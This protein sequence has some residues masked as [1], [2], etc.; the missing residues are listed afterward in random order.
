MFSLSVLIWKHLWGNCF[1]RAALSQK[2]GPFSVPGCTPKLLAASATPN[3]R[4]FLIA[5]VCTFLKNLTKVENLLHGKEKLHFFS[6]IKSLY[7]I[8]S[9]FRFQSLPLP[10]FFIL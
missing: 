5:R 8:S 3:F 7:L 6:F 10:I 2:A 1:E 4:F 9:E